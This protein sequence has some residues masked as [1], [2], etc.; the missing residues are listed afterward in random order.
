MA[1]ITGIMGK[2]ADSRWDTTCGV[3]APRCGC[4][5]SRL[6]RNVGQI[7]VVNIGLSEGG[8]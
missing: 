8:D 6:D 4:G 2:G 3:V 7:E 5:C 1:V